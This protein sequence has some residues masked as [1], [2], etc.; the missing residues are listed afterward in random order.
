[1]PLLRTL[2]FASLAAAIVMPSQVLAATKAIAGHVQDS[3][4]RP[5][6]HVYLHQE[7]GMT[8]AFTDEL[9]NFRLEV[10]PKAA[11]E[12]LASA[13]GY[14]SVVI[15]MAAASEPIVLAKAPTVTVQ[16]P[17]AAADEEAPSPDLLNN[18]FGLRYDWRNG[19]MG[20]FSNSIAG[21]V[22]N[23]L[24]LNW[25]ARLDDWLWTLDAERYRAAIK[26]PALTP[27]N[28]S[29][30]VFSPETIE[31]T[32]EL[33]Y[34][35]KAGSLEF[36][37]YVAGLWRQGT[38]GTSGAAYTGTPLD[39]DQIRQAVGLGL[40]GTTRLLPRLVGLAD[41]SYYTATNVT[42]T[43]APY[44]LT[45]L[46]GGKLKLGLGYDLVPSIRLDVGYRHDYWRAT[47]YSEDA[48]VVTVGVSYHPAEVT[49]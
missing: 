34:A 43:N 39:W 3:A 12:L 15:G 11:S 46:T 33:G 29:A 20:S 14:Q 1:M 25:R 22:D 24:G 23:E 7:N 9:G 49:P 13:P 48:D 4:G 32:L 5:L 18:Q 44:Q 37:P 38:A 30:T 21:A 31:G 26:V 35:L 41:L 36:A 16:P 6:P 8:S 19:T 45:G 27:N 28:P 40:E 10:D 2:A 17:E 42:L 47:N